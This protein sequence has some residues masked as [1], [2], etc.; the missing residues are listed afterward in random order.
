MKNNIG[1]G[2]GGRS[3]PWHRRGESS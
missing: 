3:K 2:G 1:R